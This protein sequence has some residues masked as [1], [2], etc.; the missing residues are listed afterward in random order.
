MRVNADRVPK[1][2]NMMSHKYFNHS[3]FN[4]LNEFST[5]YIDASLRLKQN[6]VNH[7]IYSLSLKKKTFEKCKTTRSSK[8]NNIIVGMK[9]K[10]LLM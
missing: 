7:N 1:E 5:K 8:C 10:P 2:Q 4:V 6:V 9:C 3:S